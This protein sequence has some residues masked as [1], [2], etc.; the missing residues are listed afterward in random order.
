MTAREPWFHPFDRNGIE[1]A[2]VRKLE[3]PV[4]ELELAL[5]SINRLTRPS[6]LDTVAEAMGDDDA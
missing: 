1:H 2:A 6:L 5:N 3:T 4:H